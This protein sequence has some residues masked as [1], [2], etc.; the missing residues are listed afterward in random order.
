M[1]ADVDICVRLNGRWR[2]G[3]AHLSWNKPLH[4][5]LAGYRVCYSSDTGTVVDQGSSPIDIA[6]PDQ[7]AIDLTGLTMY[8][9]Y[10]FCLEPYKTGG[11]PMGESNHVPILPTDILCHLPLALAG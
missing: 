1:Y 9:L 7:L 2:D 6:V 10:D 8:S 5:D 11:E 3:T 4:P